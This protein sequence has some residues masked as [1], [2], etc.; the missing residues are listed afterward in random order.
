M[1][2]PHLPNLESWSHRV[3]RTP[4]GRAEELRG[5]ILSKGTLEGTAAIGLEYVAAHVE[6]LPYDVDD[7]DDK[8]RGLDESS[9]MIDRIVGTNELF[10]AT[11]EGPD[12]AFRKWTRD[13]QAAIEDFDLD[14]P[15]SNKSGFEDLAG[16]LRKMASAGSVQDSARQL[17]SQ[18]KKIHKRREEAR[19]LVK[20][21]FT[22][23]QIASKL[24]VSE[25]AIS[26][27]LNA[28]NHDD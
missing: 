15:M 27:D 1:P 12:E 25:S 23:S 21:G 6:L 8:G 22:Q 19:K 9:E 14:E 18:Q 17:T 28:P 24:S 26:R 10:V 11:L 2:T 7:A 16:R 5:L 13:L 4:T 20:E 3:E